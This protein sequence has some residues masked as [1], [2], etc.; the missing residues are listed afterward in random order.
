[1][2]TH[3]S[4]GSGRSLRW[5]RGPGRRLARGVLARASRAIDPHVLRQRLLE[6]RT[7]AFFELHGVRFHMGAW[8]TTSVRASFYGGVYE[9]A[10]RQIVQKTLRSDDRVIE[11]GCGI[12]YITTIAARIAGSVRAFDA[13]PAMTTACAETLQLN[14]ARAEV[15]NAVCMAEPVEQSVPFYLDGDFWTSSLTARPGAHRIDVATRDFDRELD[16]TRC[17]YLLVDIEG[18]ETELLHRTLPAHVRAVCVECH[19]DTCEPGA[20]SDMFRALLTQGFA[21]DL[22]TSRQPVFYLERSAAT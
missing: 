10:E 13:N 8:A 16:E 7:P 2:S 18:G 14:D 9:D 3:R 6:A 22:A 1:V 11:L 5:P 12:G 20:I 15:I 21:I 17:S 4:P 19:P